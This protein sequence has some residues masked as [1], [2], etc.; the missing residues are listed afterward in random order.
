VSQTCSQATISHSH[1]VQGRLRLKFAH[2]PLTQLTQ[3]ATC[4]QQQPL[5]VIRAFP[6]A[7]GGVLVHLHNLSGGILGGDLLTLEI[8]VGADAYAQLTST[9]ATR[10][11]RC[12]PAAPMARQTMTVQVH[13]N[14]LLEYVPDP[15]IP[16]AGARYQQQT[17][18][19]LADGAGLFWWETVAPGRTAHGECFAYDLLQLEYTI[20][21][22]GKPLAIERSRLMPQQHAMQSLARLGPYRY[23][24]SFYICRVGLAATRWLQLE[25][26][27]QELAYQ[28]SRPDEIIWGVSTLT[29]HGLVVRVL[30]CQGREIAQGLL[31]FWRE[32]K[33]ALYGQ[34]ASPPRK[35]Y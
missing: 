27:L 18:I 13:S 35:I 12:R 33:Q 28:F 17:Q 4:E 19:D 32:A 9:S 30:S 21:A 8:E 1:R 16:F 26:Q 34:V 10:L 7:H 2:D 25:Q 3:L 20:T 5:Q 29:A 24:G 6:L 31:S 22:G 23:M 14:G 15:L 11:Y